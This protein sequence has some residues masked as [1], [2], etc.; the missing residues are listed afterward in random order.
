M[1]EQAVRQANPMGAA[2]RGSGPCEFQR[3]KYGGGCVCVC[4][5]GAGNALIS[6]ELREK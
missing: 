5:V 1:F 6:A 4:V 3:V 2:G